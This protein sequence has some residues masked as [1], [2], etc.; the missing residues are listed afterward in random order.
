[1]RKVVLKFSVLCALALIFTSCDKDEKIITS[2]NLPSLANSFLNDY[3]KD[4]NIVSI[5][6]EMDVIEGAEYEVLFS[7]GMEVTFDKNG[8]WDEVEAHD[9]KVAIPTSFILPSIVSYVNENYSPALINSIDKE[10]S[11]FEVEL[12]NGID[13][14]FTLQGEF[15][16]AKL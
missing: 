8:E 12:T 13:L 1:M 10:K 2:D 16:K 14:I 4:V 9:D 3:F 6:E 5:T 11:T 7:N 15:L